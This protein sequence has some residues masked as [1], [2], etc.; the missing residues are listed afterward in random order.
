MN[1]I[2]PVTVSV[3]T[4]NSSKTIIETLESIK[5]QSYP[6]II[7]QV[8]DDKSIDSTIELCNSWIEKNRDRFI[9]TRVIV[10][11]SNTGVSCNFNRSLDNCTTEYLKEIAGDD[12]LTDD[13]ITDCMEYVTE[14]PDC[15]ILF[16]RQLA[17][18]DNLIGKRSFREWGDYK[19]FTLSPQE[20]LTYLLGKGN[21]V[22]A[23]SAFY[24]VSNLRKMNIR[25][26][27]RIPMMEDWPKWVNFLRKG[28]QFHFLNKTLVY[29]RLGTGI[30][31][32]HNISRNY[33]RSKVLFSM[34]YRTY[35]CCSSMGENAL[36]EI[37]QEQTMEVMKPLMKNEKHIK[38]IRYLLAA[39]VSLFVM[40]FA[41][42]FLQICIVY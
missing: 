24:N 4:Y 41:M 14:H 34:L 39:C 2:Q 42:L 22:P 10:P 20:Q 33:I 3:I 35:D 38:Q 26:D 36:E 7:L 12:L 5:A 9:E 27:E 21:D 17:F 11:E 30:S 40:L 23:A 25:N 28:G 16:G 19:F 8:C 18:K 6:K 29:Y 15:T 1:S 32:H 31:S 13:C 37:V